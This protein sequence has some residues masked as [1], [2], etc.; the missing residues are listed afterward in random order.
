[1]PE[2]TRASLLPFAGKLPKLGARVF[3]ADG[4]RLIG[5]LEIGDDS[6]IWFNTV[7]RADVHSI[8]IGA[9]TNIQDNT[10]IHVTAARAATTIGADVTVGHGAIIHG[11]TVGD[12]CLIGMGAILLDH[13]VIG[14]GSM[15]GAGSLVTQGKTFPPGSLIMGSPAK[16]VRSLSAEEQ[17]QL[18]TSA[19]H[20]VETAG[21]YLG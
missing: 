10:T 17:A 4:A 18:F 21:R 8:R 9:R 20:Y 16:V 2:A 1:M 15:V 12:G 19:R 11:C 14:P 6:S 13:A 5:D 3:V 7:I